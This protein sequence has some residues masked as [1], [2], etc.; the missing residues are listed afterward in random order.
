MMTNSKA[1]FSRTFAVAAWESFR[2]CRSWEAWE[3]NAALFFLGCLRLVLL[4]SLNL[5]YFNQILIQVAKVIPTPFCVYIFSGCFNFSSD[6][7]VWISMNYRDGSDD[8]F[9]RW[10]KLNKLSYLHLCVTQRYQARC[11]WSIYNLQALCWFSKTYNML[12]SVGMVYALIFFFN[13]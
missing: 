6:I 13:V 9:P 3:L 4:N 10:S 11:F 1:C 8:Y 2:L 12:F 5:F 7:V